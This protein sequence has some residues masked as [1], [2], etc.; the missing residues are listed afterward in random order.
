MLLQELQFNIA[1]KNVGNFLIFFGEEQ[2]VSQIYID[3]I[4]LTNNL[5]VR[6]PANIKEMMQELGIKSL[7]SQHKLFIIRDD[8]TFQKNEK[9]W[10]ELPAY[11]GNNKLILLYTKMD[12]RL[13]FYTQNKSA[14]VEFEKLKPDVLAKYIQQQINLGSPQA[15]KLAEICSCDYGR[16]LLEADKLENLYIYYGGSKTYSDIF[17]IAI[18]VELFHKDPA[19]KVFEFVDSVLSNDA[20]KAFPRLAELKECKTAN[21]LML[22][23]LYT[24]FRNLLL[25][26]TNKKKE[27]TGLSGWQSMQVSNKINKYATSEIIENLRLV[28]EVEK[29]SKVGLID[30]EITMNY[31]LARCLRR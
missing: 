2:C 24:G 11:M 6:R 9:L 22:S 13:R 21:V 12:K 10:K 4:V 16:A 18:S 29:L 15:T 5:K 25:V 31:V 7:D 3:R 14:M 17:N 8:S 30:P 20:I 1:K 23:L 19:D 28:R 27:T 26:Q